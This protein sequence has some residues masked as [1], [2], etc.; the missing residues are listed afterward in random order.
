MLI[1]TIVVGLI[2]SSTVSSLA[3]PKKGG[4]T[5]VKVGVSTIKVYVKNSQVKKLTGKTESAKFLGSSIS[6]ALVAA[7]KAT[8]AV[9]GIAIAAISY[10]SYRAKKA[11]KGNGVFFHFSVNWRNPARS[12]VLYKVTGQ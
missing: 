8:G 5:K 12:L 6:G 7:G 3:A 2:L 11:N 10:W 1:I 9:A 4:V